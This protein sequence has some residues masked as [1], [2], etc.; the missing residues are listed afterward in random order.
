VIEAILE[1]DLIAE[2]H[3]K[4]LLLADLL[5]DCGVRVHAGKGLLAGLEFSG[6]VE[7]DK[8]VEACRAKN[9]LVVSTDRKWVKLGP[10]YTISDED[11]AIGAA[12]L[13]AAILEVQDETHR[14]SGQE[15]GS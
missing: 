2:S 7:A 6:P 14:D 11:L 3:R 13:I 8:V 12:K 1:K 10:P 9:L 4:G 5:K 15:S